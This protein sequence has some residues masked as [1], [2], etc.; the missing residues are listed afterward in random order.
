MRLLLEF[1]QD[2]VGPLNSLFA[3]ALPTEAAL[4]AIARHSPDGVVEI[5]AGGGLWA[6]LLRAR[7]VTLHAY[8]TANTSLAHTLVLEGGPDAAARHTGCSLLLCWPPLEHSD[9]SSAP[10][11]M[12]LR[13]LQ[14]LRGDGS[15]LYVG[16]WH[17]IT[18]VISSLA[19]STAQSGQTA[20]H[21]FQ[22]EVERDWDLV[23]SVALPRWPGMADR[24][25]ILRRRNAAPMLGAASASNTV[26]S[27]RVAAEQAA[28]QA[29]PPAR[30]ALEEHAADEASLGGEETAAASPHCRATDEPGQEHSMASALQEDRAF[31][32]RLQLLQAQGSSIGGNPLVIAAAV[33]ISKYHMGTQA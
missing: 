14:A 17:G 1:H 26:H 21:N 32:Q 28:E 33:A 30:R 8:D 10:N 6:H 29:V 24:L 16:E 4:A 27:T 31:G 7:G 13:A 5:G 2:T 25:F 9:E 15:L 11:L 22:T 3:Y 20:G 23:D 19:Q 18:G 12:A